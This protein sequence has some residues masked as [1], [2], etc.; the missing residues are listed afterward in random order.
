V[1][2]HALNLAFGIVLHPQQT[3]RI[4]INIASFDDISSGALL[5]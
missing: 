1:A 3:P 2:H 5:N 4:I